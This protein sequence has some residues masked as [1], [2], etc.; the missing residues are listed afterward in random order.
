MTGVACITWDNV[1]SGSEVHCAHLER[2]LTSEIYSDRKL[3][4][5]E[6]ILAP[7]YSIMSFTGNNIQPHDDL[8]S[9]SLVVNLATDRVDPENREFKRADPVGW[10]RLHRGEILR[11]LYTILLGN[12][13]RDDIPATR[14]KNWMALVGTAV[15]YAA[16]LTDARPPA[17]RLYP[18]VSFKSAFEKTE[19][20]DSANSEKADIL[21][22]LRNL[23]GDGSFEAIDV[24]RHLMAS[25]K[26]EEKTKEPEDA[27]M[28]ELR[29]FCTAQRA[30]H[31][32]KKSIGAALKGIAN[33]PTMT[34][35]GVATLKVKIDS[36]SRKPEFRI[37]VRR[38]D[39]SGT[40]SVFDLFTNPWE[41]PHEGPCEASSYAQ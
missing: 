10:T 17:D 35:W 21:T 31:P 30:T 9:R 33:G 5:T 41:Q 25:E 24:L 4:E 37:T 19:E 36:H 23:F 3:G 11:A 8:A 29:G 26:M 27:E 2:A 34:H 15:E 6:T 1:S 12:P 13:I 14:F 39:I 32:T 18:A 22:T 28:L 20:N 7:A 38:P 16:E 40:D